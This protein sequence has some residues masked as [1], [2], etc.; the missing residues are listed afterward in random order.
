VP[1]SKTS[2]EKA[3]SV[4]SASTDGARLAK[5]AVFNFG[6]QILP[7]LSGI[8]L[9]PYIVRNLGPDRFGMLGI[10]WVVFGYFSLMDL[11][12]GRATT[13]FLAEWLAKGE[14]S[15][16]SEMVW[17]SIIL[18]LL[19]GVAGGGVMA[20]M[21]PFLVEHV[22][23]TPPSLVAEARTAFYVLA[24]ALPSILT[25]NGLRAVLE[26]CQRFDITNLLRIPANT[27]AFVI[28]AA[29]VAAGFGLPG[30][31]LWMGISR[32]AFTFAHGFY[33]LQALPCLKTKPILRSSAI[34]PLLSFGGWVTVSNAVN[35][36]L[37]WMDRF[38][39]GSVLS[40]AMV[41]YYT[42]PFEAVT[43]VW[44]IPVS[45][46]TTVYPACSALGLERITA[47]QVLYSRL[48]KYIFC[49][50]APVILIVVIFARP[51]MNAWLG[52]VF[53]AK[54][55][56]PLQFLAVGVFIN[57]FVHV[58]YSFLQALGRP[59]PAAKVFLLELAPYGLLLWWMIGHYGI[60]GA[61]AAWSIRVAIELLLLLWIA[62]RV[63]TLSAVPMVDR[64]MWA[65]LAAMTAT[66]AAIYATHFFLGHAILADVSACAVWLAG[67]I[68]A[69]WKWVLD[70]VDRA[71]ALAVMS[72][73]QRV[74][75]KSFGSVEAD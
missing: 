57:C 35:P 11:G 75:E 37:L 6:G 29:A 44:M 71:S 36:L 18:Q 59:E 64:T 70:S 32:V 27:L 12:M 58:P 53:A 55:V 1:A 48:I 16:I 2:D 15:R 14:E 68:F 63:F 69:V 72:P 41:G 31:V 74:V 20:A 43:K 10:I 66:G 38:M 33:C 26:G 21:T 54:S 52:P 39:I 62:W 19:L 47:L 67:F 5:N 17:S 23:K 65:A 3:I 8:V 46:M 34:F 28:P 4:I 45:L 30:M 40:V 9:I 25:M 7:L 42:A 60:A 24:A 56:L 22:L 13:K 50:L 61:A 73:L 51:I 49:T